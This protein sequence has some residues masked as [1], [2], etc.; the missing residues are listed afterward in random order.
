MAVP[1]DV[2]GLAVAVDVVSLV[3]AVV[4][5]GLLGA[6]DVVIFVETVVEVDVDVDG[7][8]VE[9][10]PT[11][12]D[13]SF[14]EETETDVAGALDAVVSTDASLGAET[15]TEEVLALVGVA[16]ATEVDLTEIGSGGGDAETDTPETSSAWASTGAANMTASAAT[17]MYALLLFKSPTTA[18][19]QNN[20]LIRV[21]LS[22]TRSHIIHSQTS[23]M[24]R[25]G[26]RELLRRPACLSV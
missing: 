20:S 21:F 15:D 16:T 24:L 5:V 14:G 4:V 6:L 18:N 12:A 1:V 7:V 26:A 17:Q 19:S 10:A 9:V 2:V 25:C 11:S 23:A 13:A 22:V 3:A 8:L